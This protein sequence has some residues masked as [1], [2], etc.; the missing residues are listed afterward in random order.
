MTDRKIDAMIDAED[1]GGVIGLA[2][3]AWMS[4]AEGVFC[5]C[6]EPDVVGR[7]LMCARCN[8]EVKSQREKRERERHEPHPYEPMVGRSD[9]GMCGFCS[10]W[11]DDPIHREAE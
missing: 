11:Q 1:W 4:A 9:F 5:R 8:L 10:R 2:V 7:D 6:T 3:N